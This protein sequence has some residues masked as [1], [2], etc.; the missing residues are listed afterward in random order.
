MGVLENFALT[1]IAGI[2]SDANCWRDIIVHLDKD[3]MKLFFLKY[4]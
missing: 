3:K 4:I 2:Q 1:I